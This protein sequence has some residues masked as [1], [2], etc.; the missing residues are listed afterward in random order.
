[1]CLQE[2]KNYLQKGHAGDVTADD[3]CPFVTERHTFSDF[4]DGLTTICTCGMRRS[5]WELESTNQVYCMPC[6]VLCVCRR[7]KITYRKV[8]RCEWSSLVVGAVASEAGPV[9]VCS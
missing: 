7:K 3:S 4:V 2:K 6:E 1:M 5:P 8:T 9:L